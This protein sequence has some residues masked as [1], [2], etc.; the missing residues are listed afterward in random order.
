MKAFSV[1]VACLIA[2]GACSPPSG[3]KTSAKAEPET[4]P[5]PDYVAFA[6]RPPMSVGAELDDNWALAI[7]A[8]RWSYRIGRALE[9]L[10]EDLPPELQ[11]TAVGE[12]LLIRAHLGLRNSAIRL[13]RLRQVACGAKHVATP[14]DCSAFSTPP[15]FN[16]AASETALPP[17]NEL[18]MRNHWFYEHA[19]QFVLPACAKGQQLSNDPNFCTAE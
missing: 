4:W 19:D 18:L 3:T 14:A 8:E 13:A 12:I 9:A 1:L 7:D 17:K 16:A 2:L 10:G 15:W 5:P 6:A 11:E